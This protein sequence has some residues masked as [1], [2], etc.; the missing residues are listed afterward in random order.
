MTEGAQRL[1]RSE[2]MS[3]SFS[4]FEVGDAHRKP[5]LTGFVSILVLI[6]TSV[7]KPRIAAGSGLRWKFMASFS[8]HPIRVCGAES[9]AS[10]RVTSP[11]Y[12]LGG[13]TTLAVMRG[14]PRSMEGI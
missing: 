3:L 5:S 6:E 10:F 7:D 14:S 9:G 13:T 11:Q 4:L 2:A 1:T 8:T 12:Q